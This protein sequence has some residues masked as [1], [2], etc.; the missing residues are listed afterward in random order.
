MIS[1]ECRDMIGAYRILTRYQMDIFMISEFY[2]P[3]YPSDYSYRNFM[4]FSGKY[5]DKENN[6]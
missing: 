6:K 1:G 4:L 3:R 5:T 2:I